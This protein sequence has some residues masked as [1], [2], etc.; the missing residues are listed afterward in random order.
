LLHIIT[1]ILINIVITI[2]IITT[3]TII[4]INNNINNNN[5]TLVIVTTGIVF[6]V[7]HHLCA[8][9]PQLLSGMSWDSGPGDIGNPLGEM[10]KMDFENRLENRTIYKKTQS[11]VPAVSRDLHHLPRL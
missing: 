9:H 3:T 8:N 5:I 1:T 10:C 7:S 2:T 11:N 4:I 6:V